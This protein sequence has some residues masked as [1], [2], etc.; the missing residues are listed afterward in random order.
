MNNLF[1]SPVWVGLFQ[2]SLIGHDRIKQLASEL[3]EPSEVTMSTHAEGQPGAAAAP[4]GGTHLGRRH[5]QR[6]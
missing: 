2:P 1:C 3:A 6:T 4:A 5:C